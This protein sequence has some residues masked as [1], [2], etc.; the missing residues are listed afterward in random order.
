MKIG[1]IIQART[2]ATRLPNKVL[3]PIF[4]KEILLHEVERVLN[5][6][7]LDLVV[8][9]TTT[10]PNDDK[11]EK[12]II[13]Y[14]HPKVK[15]FRGSEEDVLDRYYRAARENQIEMVIRI[16]GDCPLI[17]WE[18]MD[19]II[20][21]F[22]IGDYD[23][24]SN[25]LT[26]RTYPRGLD[27]E[28]FSFNVL[29]WMW[30]NCRLEREREHVTT[31][32]REHPEQFKIKNIEQTEDLSNLRWTLDEKDDFILIEEIYRVLYPKKRFFQTQDILDLITQRPELVKINQHIE[33]KK[34]ILNE[35]N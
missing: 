17:D 27:I 2:G 30:K 10:Q 33:Q 3:L 23:Y 7:K 26:K 34:N 22:L 20:E 8:I 13:D 12:L 16:T 1:C 19:K 5:S 29:E 4:G 15:L 31:Y 21:E 11:I 25:V 24:V 32:V 28:I 14:N 9:A 35:V 18:L 6:K